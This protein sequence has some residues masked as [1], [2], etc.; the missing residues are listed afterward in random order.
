VYAYAVGTNDRTPGV[1]GQSL[2][3]AVPTLCPSWVPE[4]R[5][6]EVN[7]QMAF[8]LWRRSP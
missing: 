5:E 1:L 2:D 6:A 7:E 8:T 4:L 3:L